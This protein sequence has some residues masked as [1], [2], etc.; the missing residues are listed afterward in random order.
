MDDDPGNAARALQDRLDI[1]LKRAVPLN[2]KLLTTRPELMHLVPTK[3][4]QSK[5]CS[6]NGIDLYR[7]HIPPPP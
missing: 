4:T 6:A 5:P 3:A 2:I 1:R 7:G